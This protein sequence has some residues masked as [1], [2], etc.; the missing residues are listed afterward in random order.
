MSAASASTMRVKA[1]PDHSESVGTQS[2]QFPTLYCSVWI[3]MI[4]VWIS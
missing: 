3:E 2:M 1:G 4:I